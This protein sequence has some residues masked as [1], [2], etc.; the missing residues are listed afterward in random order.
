MNSILQTG[1]VFLIILFLL[2]QILISAVYEN[3]LI[4]WIDKNKDKDG[5]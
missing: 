4:D 3:D 5:E 1:V 2:T